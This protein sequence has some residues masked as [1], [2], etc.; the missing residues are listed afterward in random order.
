MQHWSPNHAA[1]SAGGEVIL[2]F[3]VK[4]AR[5]FMTNGCL[6][7]GH[8]RPYHLVYRSGLS[9]PLDPDVHRTPNKIFLEFYTAEKRRIPSSPPDARNAIEKLT[10][11]IRTQGGGSD[12]PV[13][14]APAPERSTFQGA[15]TSWTVC[16]LWGINSRSTNT[17]L[18]SAAPT[19]PAPGFFMPFL[20]GAAS[21]FIY[22][23]TARIYSPTA[24]IYIMYSPT[25]R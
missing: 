16:C 3:R 14:G 23:P 4:R 6:T 22:I 5:C 10:P 21:L 24:H 2:S 13:G 8:T 11:Q 1:C 15:N 18:R 25:A 9:L 20:Y 12:R 19:T 17:R 7:I